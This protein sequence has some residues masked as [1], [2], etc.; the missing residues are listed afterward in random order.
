MSWSPRPES[1]SPESPV[2]RIGER[3]RGIVGG[4]ASRALHSILRSAAHAD[5]ATTTTTTDQHRQHSSCVHRKD[6]QAGTVRLLYNERTTT[7]TKT[8]EATEIADI[9][10]THDRAYT[11]RTERTL[12]R[13]TAQQQRGPP[14]GVHWGTGNEGHSGGGSWEAGRGGRRR[15]SGP[16]GDGNSAT[17][18]RHLRYVVEDYR[19]DHRTC[20][21]I[22][23]LSTLS[24]VSM[25]ATRT[26]HTRTDSSVWCLFDR[27]GGAGAPCLVHCLQ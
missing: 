24:P 26:K 1:P 15:W 14:T 27:R 25:T 16:V 6:R 19:L 5:A 4:G 7:L 13:R 17:A 10:H 20:T 21:F 12:T 22:G 23:F 11:T 3:A 8:A 18:D 2:K 9:I